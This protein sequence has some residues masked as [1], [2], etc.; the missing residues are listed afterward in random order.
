MH[1]ITCYIAIVLLSICNVNAQEPKRL[2]A[3]AIHDEIKKLNFLGSVLYVAA[4]PDDENTTLI[5]YL[6]NHVHA[7]TAYL[8]LTRG[9]G[10]QNLIGPE[11]RE[12]LGLLRTQELLAARNVDGGEQ[13]FTRANDFGYSK[14]PDETLAI[15]DKKEVLGDVVWAI[16]KFRPDVIINRFN[17]R[18][19]GTTHGHH[20]SSAML[21][22]EAYETANNPN[23]YK[24]QLDHYDTWQPKRVMFNTSWWFY[25]SRE[26][27]AAADKSNLITMDAGVYYP[28][29]GLSNNEISAISRSQ[30]KCQGFGRLTTRGTQDEYLEHI[31][32]SFPKNNDLFYG[33]DTSWNRVK[34]GKAIG[35]ILN[36]VEKTFN[37]NDPSTHLP[38]LVKAY[39]LIQKIEDT[40]WKNLKSKHI[41]E[42]IEA[43]SGLFIEAI[44]NTGSSNPYKDVVVSLELIN[45]SSIP[46]ELVSVALPNKTTSKNIITPKPLPSNITVE[47]KQQLTLKE[48]VLSTPYWLEKEG[49]LGM[50]DVSDKTMIGLPE[51]PQPYI[52]TFNIKMLGTTI[53]IKKPIVYKYADPAVGEIYEPF[54]ILP[55]ATINIQDNMYIFNS[56]DTKEI[57]VTV[58]S[59]Q[60]YSEGTVAVDVPEGWKISPKESTFSISGIGAMQKFTFKLTPPSTESEGY[61]TPY[62]IID[63]KR[64]E[65][66]LVTINY[67][68]I[69]KQALLLPAKA[70]V[71]KLDIVKKGKLVG[72]IKGTGDVTPES[73]EHIGYDVEQININDI[74]TNSIS[75]YD[76]IVV[77]IRAY[78]IYPN[79]EHKQKILFDYVKNGGNMIV[80]YNTSHRIKV[81]ELAPY[82]LKLSRDRV[83]DENAKV[84]FLAPNHPALNTPN[85]ITSKDF[86][87]WVQERGLYFPNEWDNAFT[88][89]LAMNDKNET[90]KNGSLLIA[91]YGKGHY[92][93]TGLSFFRE[94]PSG[95]SGAYRLFAN[96]VS[97]GK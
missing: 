66:N 5:S 81:N 10:G 33:I 14:H 13:F 95:V 68:H 63:N 72:Y 6:S 23:A 46:M 83:T 53:P 67:D 56:E 15:W 85:K 2:T 60:K 35:D 76:A 3:S 1:K 65:K 93:Y 52:Y 19:P 37:F 69:P 12:Q 47:E 80:Q 82:S 20:T 42:I 38:D 26:K 87:G 89:I 62:V 84:T 77:G 94:F 7:R 75:K 92:V 91:A 39:N 21:S 61:I 59:G 25:G 4:H 28:S 34:G 24:W 97:L 78:N 11:L 54:H 71:V 30:H 29:K 44:T 41:I 31:K 88:P 49:S 79:L 55:K 18:T 32:G 45:R 74:T 90:V 50:Y 58:R 16:R 36:N 40:H 70:K 57:S 43:C 86:D 27:F 48:H 8:S 64:I 22:L 73:L 9:D 96:L 51:T 17:H